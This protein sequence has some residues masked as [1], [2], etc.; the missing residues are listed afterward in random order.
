MFVNFIIKNKKICGIFK[1]YDI[2]I[3]VPISKNR[4]SKRGYNQTELIS[5]KIAKYIQ[6]LIYE[7]DVLKKVKN[8]VP[9]STL[10]KQERQNNVNNAYIVVS[11]EKI[12]GKSLIL[13]DDV[14]TTGSTV[15]ECSKVLKEAGA[16]NID[17]LTIAKD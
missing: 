14:F 13:L 9:Q 1:N 10:T 7:P 2:I 12:Q 4:K 11:K 6:N 15:N 17:V 16:R 3:P 8:I 5:S